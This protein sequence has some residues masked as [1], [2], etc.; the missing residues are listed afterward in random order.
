MRLLVLW[1]DRERAA[2][3]C[4][5]MEARGWDTD[6][7]FDGR[8]LLPWTQPYDVL[9]LHLCLPGMDGLSAG[10]A[11]ADACPV[12]PPRILFAAPMEWCVHRPAWADLTIAS[13]GDVSALCSLIGILA[14]KPLSALALA[15]QKPLENAIERF[16]DDLSFSGR[17]KGRAYAAWLLGRMTPST[18]ADEPPLGALYADCAAFFETSP[19][20]VERC[21]RTAIEAV[22]TQGSLRGI[23]RF[24]GATVDPERGK[25]TNRAF[26]MQAA[27]QL[28]YSFT[29]SR[30]PNKSDMHHRPAAPTSV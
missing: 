25:P 4:A 11:L 28:R 17:L 10:D 21:L 2:A 18:S 9:L 19:A 26:L 7:R 5:E 12:R 3:I 24:F 13:G 20:A 15:Q 8:E 22:F 23:E 30:S 6:V 1:P 14:Q 29:A 16:L 27:E